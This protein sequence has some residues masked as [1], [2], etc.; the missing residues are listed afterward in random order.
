MWAEDKPAHAP[1]PTYRSAIAYDSKNDRWVLHGG[2]IGR[3]TN[4]NQTWAYKNG[5][6]TKLEEGSTKAIYGHSI[7]DTP[8]GLVMFGGIEILPNKRESAILNEFR[9]LK[10]DTSGSRWETFVPET[11]NNQNQRIPA[12]QGIGAVYDPNTE[13]VWILGGA[14]LLANRWLLSDTTYQLYL[15]GKYSKDKGWYLRGVGYQG[16]TNYHEVVQ[17]LA[18]MQPGDKK[19][20]LYGG[21]GYDRGG[22]IGVFSNELWV[23]KQTETNIEVSAGTWPKADYAG[24]IHGAFDPGR[25]QLVLHS[26]RATFFFGPDWQESVIYDV[27]S[28][29]WAKVASTNYP[30]TVVGPTIATNPK[31]G[32]FLRFGGASYNWNTKEWEYSHQTW[33]CSP[34]Y[35]LRLPVMRK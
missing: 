31:T 9:I 21:A 24:R 4:H 1:P 32:E 11:Q 25:N 15:P 27:K 30:P 17:P 20:Y 12:L 35:T 2:Y 18:F 14:S 10:E 29:A 13:S 28:G 5:D 16:R 7:I 22:G 26:G 34:V 8:E 3:E 6:W 19:I 33:R 23:I